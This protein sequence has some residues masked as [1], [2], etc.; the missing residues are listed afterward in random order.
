MAWKSTISQ[1]GTSA[2]AVVSASNGTRRVVGASVCNPTA[3]AQTLTLYLVKSGDAAAADV[4]LYSAQSVGA[5]AVVILNAALNI[6]LAE[7]DEI[8]ALASAATSLT[9]TMSVV[10]A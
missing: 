10:D 1:P 3:G 8:H 6:G 9:L 4:A 2:A 7:G 5:G